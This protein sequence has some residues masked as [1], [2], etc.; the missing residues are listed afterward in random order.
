MITKQDI[1]IENS[2]GIDII[3]AG[4]VIEAY[5][6]RYDS[7][8]SGHIDDA[9]KMA[10]NDQIDFIKSSLV[11][12]GVTEDSLKDIMAKLSGHASIYSFRG[13]SELSYR[14]ASKVI[15]HIRNNTPA[16]RNALGEAGNIANAKKEY[17][18]Y[19]KNTPIWIKL[20]SA[21][22]NDFKYILDI[23]DNKGFEQ[24]ISKVRLDA[25]PKNI[26]KYLEMSDNISQVQSFDTNTNNLKKVLDE[27]DNNRELA[28]KQMI[29]IKSFYNTWN[30]F[31]NK[32]K[33]LYNKTFK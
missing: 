33:E 30:E 2:S 10:T 28:N 27:Y 1:V 14:A 15:D 23:I 22:G 25:R 31:N 6:N 24:F 5:G 29:G 16:F 13:L 12:A 32:K 26:D 17:N 3:P 20:V 19:I 11:D 18:E 8:Y 7:R 21:Y 4:T 9:L